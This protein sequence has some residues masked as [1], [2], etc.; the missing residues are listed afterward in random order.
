MQQTQRLTWLRTSDPRRLASLW[1]QADSVRREAVGDEVF[2]RGLV[3]VSN[4]CRRRCAYCGISAEHKGLER[5]RM[6]T[7]EVLACAHTAVRLGYGTVVLQAGEDPGLTKTRVSDLIRQIKEQTDLAVTL[8]LGEREEDELAA[9]RA[10][11][12]DRYLAR[13][14]TSNRELFDRIHPPLNGQ[15]ADRIRL[16]RTLRVLGYEVGSGV[17]VGIPGQTYDDLARDIEWFAESE[18]DM[19]GV[20]PFVPHPVTPAVKLPAAAPEQQVPNSVEMTCKVVALARLACPKTNIPSTTALGTLDRENGTELGL[21][22]GANIV[23]PN[24]TPHGYRFLYEIYPGKANSQDSP[25]DVRE[26]L[27]RRIHGLGRTIGAGRGD[28]PHYRAGL[29]AAAVCGEAE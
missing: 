1:W 20:G 3:E 21:Q 7:E 22:R 23:M 4:I 18:L 17:M 19:I 24:L 10:A 28:S 25:A 12:A 8:S 9:W 15:P 29:A 5:Y 27:A 13:F 11:G 14:E 6:S 26:E 16:L 2:L